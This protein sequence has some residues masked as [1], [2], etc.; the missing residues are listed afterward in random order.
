MLNVNRIKQEE[1]KHHIAIGKTEE[2][3]H[4]TNSPKCEKMEQPERQSFQYY[5]N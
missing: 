3:I 5:E 2:T 4:K 1:Y